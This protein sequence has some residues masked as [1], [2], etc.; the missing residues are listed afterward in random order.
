MLDRIILFFS[1]LLKLYW[2]PYW[3]IFPVQEKMCLLFGGWFIV[4]YLF[5]DL[6]L[7]LSVGGI[8]F[9]GGGFCFCSWMRNSL[10][11]FCV[12]FGLECSSNPTFTGFLSCSSLCQM[13]YWRP[14]VLLYSISFFI[15]TSTCLACLEALMSNYMCIFVY[16]YTCI[17]LY[18][19]LSGHLDKMVSLSQRSTLS[20]VTAFDFVD[21]ICCI[22][23]VLFIWKDLHA[24]AFTLYAT[25]QLNW[26]FFMRD[27]VGS[28]FWS[29][30]LRFVSLAGQIP[31]D[32]EEFSLGH[33]VV[34][35]LTCG[36][37]VII[38]FYCLTS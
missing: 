6:G 35:L 9:L 24:F 23:F 30:K 19:F 22:V 33:C 20:L 18:M 34:F 17:C 26:I 13:E 14:L 8:F 1:E 15:S 10:Y 2:W 37:S 7:C 32:S 36:S 12:P 25:L 11:I 31:L 16:G 21:F 27:V 3:S 4:I 38:L 29:F 5:A 28:P